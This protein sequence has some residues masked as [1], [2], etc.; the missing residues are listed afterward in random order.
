MNKLTDKEAFWDLI[1]RI[2]LVA[3]AVFGAGMLFT[4]EY[5]PVDSVQRGYRGVGLVQTFQPE[6]VQAQLAANQVPEPLEPADPDSVPATEIYENVQVLRDLTDAQFI[7]VMSA[8][9]EWVSPEQGC[10]YCHA[11]GEPLSSDSLYTK[12]VARRMLQMTRDIN[13][14]WEPHV[15]QTGVTCYTCHRGQPVPAN[16]W[17]NNP[18]PPHAAGVLGNNGGQNGVSYAAGLTSLPFDPFTP[19]LSGGGTDADIRARADTALPTG[20]RSSIK[21]TEWT[22]GLMIHMSESLG[23]N[24]TY[25]HNSRSFRDWEQSS[26]V[27]VTAW[28]GI[29]MVRELNDEYID[30]LQSIFPSH[31][32]GPLGDPLKVN[33]TT[34]HA[35]VYKPFFGAGM[36]KDYPELDVAAGITAAPMEPTPALIPVPGT[37][38]Q[39][40][41]AQ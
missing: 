3:V 28:H 36:V 38:G 29:Q 31:R 4:I 22:Y 27:R 5:P 30:P 39:P 20:N 24:C 1:L 41:P 11:E 6:T 2:G 32:L 10:A 23:V 34:C 9:T 14:N 17:Y 8:I 35:G 25:C 12:V 18:G 40:A 16:V 15:A 37:D 19:F 26:P 33:C 7:R 21:Q 13:V